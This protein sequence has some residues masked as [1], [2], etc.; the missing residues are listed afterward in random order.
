MAGQIL[1]KRLPAVGPAKLVG[2]A[3]MGVDLRTGQVLERLPQA[4]L[5]ASE[6]KREGT[7][8]YLSERPPQFTGA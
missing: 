2:R 7:E 8:A 6:D 1:A 3:C 5:Y 4:L